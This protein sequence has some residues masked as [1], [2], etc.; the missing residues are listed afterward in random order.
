MVILMSWTLETQPTPSQYNL[1]HSVLGISQTLFVAT[2]ASL[3]AVQTNYTQILCTQYING[4]MV[5]IETIPG[6]GGGEYEGD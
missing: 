2:L 3:L 5:P 6:M 1:G 4:K